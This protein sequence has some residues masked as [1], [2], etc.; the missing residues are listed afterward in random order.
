MNYLCFPAVA[1]IA[2]L[3]SSLPAVAGLVE[4]SDPPADHDFGRIPL[5]AIYA[6]QYFSLSNTGATAVTLG[7]AS[8]DG[9]LSTCAA[10]GC[11]T[12]AALDFVIDAGADGCSGKTLEPGQGCSTLIGFVPSAPGGRVAQFVVPVGGASPVSRMLAG[13]GVAN[14]IDCVLD[15]A[16]RTY[17][18]LLTMPTATFVLSPFYA[19]CYQGGALCVGADVLATVAPPSVYLYQGGELLRHDDLS[20]VVAAA[21][22]E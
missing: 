14:P 1:L 7:Q 6:S 10:L 17:P 18:S 8:I 11:A 13:T 15:W 5:R 22:C 4:V 16:E 12:P 2:A 9:N 20:A 19:R 3:F 21:R